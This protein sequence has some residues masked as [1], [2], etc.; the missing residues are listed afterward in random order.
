MQKANGGSYDA[1]EASFWQNAEN[2]VPMINS[3]VEWVLSL[4]SQLLPGNRT[5][6]TTEN[7]V[8]KQ[9]E[10]VYEEKSNAGGALLALAAT[11]A[12]IFGTNGKKNK[13]K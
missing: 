1:T 6:L 11:G 3:I 7:T 8:P 10:W 4:I 13:N 12:L 2:Y 9:S 5:V